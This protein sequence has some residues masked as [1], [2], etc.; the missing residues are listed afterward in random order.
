GIA[1]GDGSQ[2]GHCHGTYRYV[3]VA[4][5]ADLMVVR[6]WGLTNGDTN[7]PATPNAVM[8]DAIRYLLNE[9]RLASKPLVINLSV[10]R[11]TDKMNGT[12]ANSQAID[13]LL[14]RN[15]VGRAIVFSAGNSGD[16]GFHAAATVPTGA[17]NTVRLSFG[18]FR[19]DAKTRTLVVLYNG[20]NLQVR[21]TS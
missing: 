6:M 14:R 21:V 12:G 18:V 5:E 15:T 8:V 20:A 2:N 11:F 16:D 17:A 9:A 1:A 10:G 4:T 3:G 7:Q 19:D 13:T